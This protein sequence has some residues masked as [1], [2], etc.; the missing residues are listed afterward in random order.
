MLE[1][2]FTE[3]T[4]NSRNYTPCKFGG[5]HNEE[6]GGTS[7]NHLMNLMDSL[8]TRNMYV[9]WFYPEIDQRLENPGKEDNPRQ[10]FHY[11]EK[12]HADVFNEKATQLSLVLRCY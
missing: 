8:S 4:T 10:T 7:L 2:S 5:H 11:A 3:R 1:Q 6:E 12:K 9:N